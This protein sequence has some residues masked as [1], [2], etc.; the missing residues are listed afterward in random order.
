MAR[1]KTE[2]PYARMQRLMKGYGLNGPKLAEVL[3]CSEPTARDR[4]KNPENLTLGEL[5]KICQ[6][7]HINMDEIREAIVR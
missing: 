3:K 2:V 6:R 1:A 4:L 7:G 5:W